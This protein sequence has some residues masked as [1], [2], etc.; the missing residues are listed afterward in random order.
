MNVRA[1]ALGYPSKYAITNLGAILVYLI[2]AS[3][4]VLIVVLILSIASKVFSSER[5]VIK[6]ANNFM[7]K[8]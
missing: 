1:E 3:C 2:L 7:N 4:L 8:T 5:V 6:F